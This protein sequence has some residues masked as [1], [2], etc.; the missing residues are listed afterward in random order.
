MTHKER[1]NAWLTAHMNT[2]EMNWAQK[3]ISLPS[4]TEDGRLTSIPHTLGCLAADR[5]LYL[6]FNL[7]L[8]S[9]NLNF[10]SSVSLGSG[11]C[12]INEHS[13]KR[14]RRRRGG[15][16]KKCSL[17]LGCPFCHPISYASGLCLCREGEGELKGD[18]RLGPINNQWFIGTFIE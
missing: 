1:V 16:E 8:L 17:S 5:Q 3:W 18:G 14:R 10:I 13:Q 7:F 15:K 9:F 12:Y 2:F 11:H 6:L 4:T